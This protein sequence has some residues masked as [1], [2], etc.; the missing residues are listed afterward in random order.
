MS[1]DFG[2]P[3][4]NNRGVIGYSNGRNRRFR[5]TEEFVNGCYTGIK[6]QCVEYARRWLV[7]VK[8]ITFKS[9][10][11]A[12]DIWALD[13]V[14]RVQDSEKIKLVKVPNG[15]LAEPQVGALLIYKRRFGLPFGHIAIITHVDAN[16][17]FVRISEQNVD[18]V[19]WPGDFARQLQMDNENGRYFIRDLYALYGWMVYEDYPDLPEEKSSCSVI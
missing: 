18:D 17:G 7:L 4:G 5:V 9:V 12:C 3:L 10:M 14:I 6:Y 19:M 2:T 15:S 13:H 16:Q 1:E 8:G 11:C